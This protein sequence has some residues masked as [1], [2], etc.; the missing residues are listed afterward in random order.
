MVPEGWP[1]PDPRGSGTEP[2]LQADSSAAPRRCGARIVALR[3]RNAVARATI[4]KMRTPS[5]SVTR[6][7][8]ASLSVSA[9]ALA[10][11]IAPPA[12]AA[13]TAAAPAATVPATAA[14]AA[15][16]QATGPLP[17]VTPITG[18]TSPAGAAL[19]DLRRARYLEREYLVTLTDP[20]VY[21]YTGGG[22]QVTATPAPPSPS[23][24]YRTRMIVRMPADPKR[25]NGRVLVEMMNTTTGLDL[26]VAWLQAHQSLVRDGW[27]YVGLTVQQ[28]GL[29]ALR[30]FTRD[31]ARYRDLGLELRTPAAVAGNAFLTSRD[32]SLAWDATSQVGRLLRGAPTSP[33]AGYRV[34]KVLLTG[35][36]QM[37]GY[38]VTY[39]NAI[40]P[41]ARVFDGFLVV[42]RSDR[43]TNLQYTADASSTSTSVAQ[44]TL[45]GG[46]APVIDIQTETDITASTVVRRPDADTAAD[47]FRLW[48]VPGSAHND[49]WMSRQGLA[50]AARD[51]STTLPSGC[52]WPPPQ[53]VTA[54]PVRY[55]WSA[56]LA[57]LDRWTTAGTRPARVPR[58]TL[59]AGRIARDRD[60]NARGG[61]RLSPIEVPIQRYG[62]SSP[63]DLFCRLTGFQQPLPARTLTARYRS[64][65]GYVAKVRTSTAADVRARILLPADAAELVAAARKVSIRPR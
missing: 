41:V 37:A 30:G 32:P 27:A 56:A 34:A 9:A 51:T 11:V 24:A 61:L 21:A 43:A 5:S 8:V 54:F 48:E 35:Q 10:A 14:P 25:F 12:A 29:D 57:A 42:S 50:L 38:L 40:Q 53:R 59:A 60:G 33:L 16:V 39:I 17:T 20:K 19:Q 22:R 28:T 49:E 64:T 2:G 23:G 7:L 62:P 45:A 58:I 26:D 18:R 63:G 44:R 1:P 52:D 55:V 15:G 6:R 31:P 13:P 65:A 36:S 4:R 3:L 47:R 46:G